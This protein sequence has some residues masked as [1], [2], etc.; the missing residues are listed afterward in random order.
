[1]VRRRSGLLRQAVVARRAAFGSTRPKAELESNSGDCQL[2][3]R[4]ADAHIAERFSSISATI[5]VGGLNP[6][7]TANR[8]IN[9]W[10]A[11][12]AEAMSQPL[13]ELPRSLRAVG[14]SWNSFM[15]Y[16][17]WNRPSENG[18]P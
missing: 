18:L 1:M 14:A 17:R 2:T 3:D 13:T 8:G 6:L 10:A 16:L 5:D 12:G 4:E 11:S 9:S 15:R 7:T